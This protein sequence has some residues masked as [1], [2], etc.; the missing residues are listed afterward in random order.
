[1]IILENYLASIASKVGVG[2]N[3]ISEIASEDIREESPQTTGEI[4]G[5]SVDKP[6]EPTPAPPVTEEEEEEVP[7]IEAIPKAKKQEKLIPIVFHW[8][9]KGNES[10]VYVC[11][12]FNN[13]EKI[14]MNK[15]YVEWVW[16]VFM[17]L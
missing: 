7:A 10:S 3:L 13:W 15:R 14:P 6:P 5:S 11:G 17:F 12:S 2:V 1:M 4:I 9:H 8:D 16:L